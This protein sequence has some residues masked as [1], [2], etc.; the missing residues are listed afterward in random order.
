MIEE[1]IE[2]TYN[3]ILVNQREE[4]NTIFLTGI[5][6]LEGHHVK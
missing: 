5:K 1:Y 4:W 3:E 6:G 2:N